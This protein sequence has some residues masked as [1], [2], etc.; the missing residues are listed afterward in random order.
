MA[1]VEIGRKVFREMIMSLNERVSKMS[2]DTIHV[3]EKDGV[4]AIN[5]SS[6][7]TQ[8]IDEAE[9]FGTTLLKVVG[10]VENFNSNIKKVSNEG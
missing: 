10:M 8:Y 5:W 7:G 1:A 4:A 6:I 2:N 3:F 9:K